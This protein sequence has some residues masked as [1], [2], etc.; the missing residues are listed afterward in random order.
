MKTLFFRKLKDALR[1]RGR[2]VITLVGGG[3]KTSLMYALAREMVEAGRKVITTTTTKIWVPL[4]GETEMLLINPDIGALKEAL[5]EHYHVTCVS[6][7]NVEG[8]AVGVKP[9]MVKLWMENLNVDCIVVEAD[10]AKGKPLKAPAA[11]EPV[12]PPSTTLYIP[13][14]GID[15]L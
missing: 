14:A 11:H 8:K 7:V 12:I 6:N 1:L 15:A 4:S 2:E 9:S 5:K 13:M 10:G 3:G